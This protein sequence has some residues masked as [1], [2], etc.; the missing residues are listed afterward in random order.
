[1]R[2]TLPSVAACVLSVLVVTK[3]DV[4]VPAETALTPMGRFGNSRLRLRKTGSGLATHL[5]TRYASRM[6]DKPD[7]ENTN[8]CI[9]PPEVPKTE[10]RNLVSEQYEHEVREIVDYIE[11]SEERRGGKGCVS[12]CRSRW[13]PYH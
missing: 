7:A 10:L 9:I 1:M 8:D 12:T 3:L 2:A 6:N 5:I 13:S 4:L 11:R